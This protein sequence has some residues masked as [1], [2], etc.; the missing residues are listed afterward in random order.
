MMRLVRAVVATLID[1]VTQDEGLS[2]KGQF[3]DL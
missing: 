1:I 3:T 2:F